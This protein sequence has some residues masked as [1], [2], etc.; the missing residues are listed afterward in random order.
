[1]PANT[2]ISTPVDQMVEFYNAKVNDMKIAVKAFYP[3]D[4]DKKVAINKHH[5]ELDILKKMLEASGM[6]EFF[7]DGSC[8]INTVALFTAIDINEEQGDKLPGS[9]TRFTSSGSS[10][11]HTNCY[12]NG[13]ISLHLHNA[14]KPTAPWTEIGQLYFSSPTKEQLEAMETAPNT[15]GE[16]REYCDFKRRL[17]FKQACFIQQKI[18]MFLMQEFGGYIPSDDEINELQY[19][20]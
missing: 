7:S 6:V 18:S 5:A 10:G 11:H 13:E 3:S 9:F 4:I 8:G 1:M 16:F 20:K 15:T 12:G 17:S 2:Q 14:G 19:S